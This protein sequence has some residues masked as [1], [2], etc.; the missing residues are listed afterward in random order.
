METDVGDTAQKHA[1]RRQD[2]AAPPPKTQLDRQQT[3][4]GAPHVPP[5][6]GPPNTPAS[7]AHTTHGTKH[8]AAR[9]TA[10]A[11]TAGPTLPLAATLLDGQSNLAHTAP[12]AAT[13]RG[14]G[15]HRPNL[16]RRVYAA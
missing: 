11:P 7:R 6:A 9:R 3:K 10:Q 15:A 1:A 16:D 4:L 14:N 2:A 8:E 5:A 13:T 12:N